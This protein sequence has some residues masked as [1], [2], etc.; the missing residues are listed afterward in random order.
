M[1]SFST[2]AS[3]KEQDSVYIKFI[4]CS[5][6]T[7][8]LPDLPKTD[9]E[10]LSIAESIRCFGLLNPICV[11]YNADIASYQII[12]GERRFS[13]MTLLG[14]TRIL[15]RVITSKETRN[16]MLIAENCLSRNSDC[17]R[18]SATVSYILNDGRI[19]VSE[20]S[21]KYGLSLGRIGNLLKLSSLTYEEKRLL[22]I[23]N[24]SERVIAEIA[25]IEDVA[26]RLPVIRYLIEHTPKL[27][28][29]TAEIKANFHKRKYSGVSFEIIR[30]TISRLGALFR[31]NGIKTQIKERT[32]EK[33][34]VY[35]ITVQK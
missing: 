17:F 5:E 28:R 1:L 22:L 9:A 25:E 15:C 13:A 18:A 2:S 32:T 10:V 19:S 27:S 33:A 3:N 12:S 24:F 14:R 8:L 23:S 35:T 34:A 26:I 21:K 20:L 7:P 29:A 6:I 31:R 16:A 4:P 30:N 11:Y